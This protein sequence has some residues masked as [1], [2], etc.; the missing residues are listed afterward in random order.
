MATGIGPGISL[1]GSGRRRTSGEA[2]EV[3]GPR[4]AETNHVRV[5]LDPGDQ[6]ISEFDLPGG[7]EF[8][9][10]LSPLTD[11]E[12]TFFSVEVEAG[13]LLIRND[14]G[15]RLEPPFANVVIPPETIFEGEVQAPVLL[16]LR[17]P[18]AL[19]S[20][21]VQP[22]RKIRV[23]VRNLGPDSGGFTTR[24]GTAF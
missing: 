16:R 10:E 14:E 15:R 8:E 21:F 9:V 6:G 18:R 24:D 1:G 7:S 19:P 2:Q 3:S 11:Q 13:G 5:I 23:R 17:V 20:G 4:H 12:E 22:L